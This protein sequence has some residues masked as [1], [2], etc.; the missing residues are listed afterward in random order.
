MQIPQT[1]G[2]EGKRHVLAASSEAPRCRTENWT[3]A[4]FDLHAL[5]VLLLRVLQDDIGQVGPRHQAFNVV[6]HMHHHAVLQ[7]D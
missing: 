1:A 6:G 2:C 3:D 4:T 7:Q 5:D